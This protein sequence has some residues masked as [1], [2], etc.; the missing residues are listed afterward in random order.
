MGGG[1]GTP[2]DAGMVLTTPPATDVSGSVP[3][4]PWNLA[5]M[6][7]HGPAEP[8]KVNRLSVASLACWACE[9]VAKMMNAHCLLLSQPVFKKTSMI[10]PYFENS[11]RKSVSEMSSGNDPTKIFVGPCDKFTGA[12][13]GLSGSRPFMPWFRASMTSH[14][15]SESGNFSVLS[16][17]DFATSASAADVKV[18]NA[19]CLCLSQ[20]VF[21]Y[22]SVIWPY[23]ENSSL[24]LVSVIESGNEP[25]KIFLRPPPLSL[26]GAAASL[27]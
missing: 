26:A 19:H 18:M 2:G 14:S 16:A 10:C 23:L 22:T 11:A 17:L 6:T 25:T 20:P 5:N 1:A 4:L 3:F 15:T 12:G 13:A 21:K 27:F 7:S 24:R 8:G 9:F